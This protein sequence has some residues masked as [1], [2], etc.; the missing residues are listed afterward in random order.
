M[1]GKIAA[2]MRTNRLRVKGDRRVQFLLVGLPVLIMVLVGTIF[3]TGGKRVPVGVISTGSG[4]LGADLVSR[5]REQPDISV[6]TY[7]HQSHLRSDVRR[8]RILAGVIIPNGYDASLRAGRPAQVH[9]VMQPG[10]TDTANARVDISEAV[11]TQAAIVTAARVARD[12]TGASLDASLRRATDLVAQFDKRTRRVKEHR[13][14]FSYTAPSNLV[15]FLFITSISFGSGFVATRRYGVLRR[16]LAT[17]TRPTTIMLGF[18]GSAVG[19]A[20]AQI[21]GLLAVGYLLFGVKWG[22][23]LALGML[24][25]LLAIAGAAANLVT[26]T[27]ANTPEQAISVGVP[28]GI[29]LGMLGGTMWPLEG[30]GPVMRAVGH[31]FPHAWAMDAFVSLIF[32][33]GHVRNVAPDLLAI[34]LWAVGLAVVASIRLRRVVVRVG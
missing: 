11:A 14:A 16:M 20:L 32:H 30:V 7:H 4:S 25:V 33:H 5:L 23:P 6:R 34:G 12:Q 10:R 26:G 27:V 15:L 8:T 17:P 29:A 24:V 22:D 13:S 28:V 9:V 2:I 31:V 1:S 21:V 18:A 19:V 3:G